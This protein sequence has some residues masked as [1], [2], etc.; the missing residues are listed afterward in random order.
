[1][2]FLLYIFHVL[3]LGFWFLVCKLLVFNHYDNMLLCSQSSNSGMFIFVVC[4]DLMICND[5]VP[6]FVSFKVRNFIHFIY[7]IFFKPMIVTIPQRGFQSINHRNTSSLTYSSEHF[8][9][10]FHT[11]DFDSYELV[12]NSWYQI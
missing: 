3:K 9:L 10:V 8:R 2:Y 5:I 7:I 11:T 4:F 1:M 6:I 12:L